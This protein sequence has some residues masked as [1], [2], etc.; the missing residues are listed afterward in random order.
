MIDNLNADNHNK[1]SR[2][3][4]RNSPDKSTAVVRNYENLMVKELRVMVEPIETHES[5]EISPSRRKSGRVRK[6]VKYNSDS[7][8]AQ[9]ISRRAKKRDSHVNTKIEKNIDEIPGVITTDTLVKEESLQ[10]SS[11]AWSLSAHDIPLRTDRP[12][13]AVSADEILDGAT[14]DEDDYMPTSSECSS[15]KRRNPPQ[16]LNI[17]C[18]V[19]KTL[20]RTQRTL[21]IHEK[22]AHGISPSTEC[23]ICKKIFTSVGNL[24]QHKQTHNDT[25]RYICSYC[26]KGFN[27]HFNLKDHINEHTGAKP[28]VCGVCG[29]AFG[30]ASH[31]VAHMRVSKTCILNLSLIFILKR[32]VLISSSRL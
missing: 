7:D 16:P 31:R 15:K 32:I 17:P 21:Q 4:A 9:P 18:S 5:D 26:G 1:L 29:K 27:L 28:Y 14:A 8:D 10:E 23:D 13:G 22:Q 11:D 30:K 12:D 25:R 20:F 19:C 6:K 3:N 24:K 2:K